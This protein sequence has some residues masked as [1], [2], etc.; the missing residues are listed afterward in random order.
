MGDQVR[1]GIISANWGVQAHLP[2]W[3][4]NDGAE[5]VAICTA[6]RETAEA[7]AKAN[8]I[9]MAF[10][11]HREMA[12]HPDIDVIDV[13]TRPSMR[14]DMCV[15]A[16]EADKHVY[17]GIPFAASLKDAN[18]LRE[19]WQRSGRVGAV[20]AYSEHLPPLVLAR[21]IINGGDIGDVFSIA[22]RLEMSLFNQPVSTFAY[23][24][25]A[26]AAYGCSAL[27][28][29]GSHA[30]NVLYA[31][32]GPV[33][34]V[35]GRPEMYVKEWRLVDTGDVITPEVADTSALLLR[36]ATGVLGTLT[37]SWV[38]VAG[39]GFS[40][41]VQGSK[42]RLVIQDGS[43]MPSNGGR[44]F[45]GKLG[46]PFAPVGLEEIPVPERLTRRNGVAITGDKDSQ[47]PVYAM[48][49]VFNDML[50]AIRDGTRGVRPGFD[51]A[52]HVQTVIEAAHR[53]V[54]TGGWVQPSAF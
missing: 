18:D 39:Q 21:E 30:L 43:M 19:A 3:R 11:D 29:L 20:D 37:T 26:D 12:A 9:P 53:S 31:L 32:F 23:N 35:V 8:A 24:W 7:A 5:V 15:A 16:F 42:G 6:H 13:G 33:A 54:E 4:A 36:F 1:V 49:C 51:Q 38:A 2:A 25:F 47:G 48:A 14:R 50:H 17:N 46:A 34:E 22:C 41:D 40:L 52:H 28:N 44:V 27:R 45:V 10:W